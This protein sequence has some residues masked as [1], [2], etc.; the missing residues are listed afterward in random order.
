MSRKDERKYRGDVEY[1][2]WRSGGNPDNVDYDRVSDY[3]WDGISPD[4]ASY[5]ETKRQRPTPTFEEE[6][7]NGLFTD[8]QFPEEE[9]R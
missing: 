1:E 8:E 9:S 4:S 7:L 6:Y 2:V 3:Y 5:R